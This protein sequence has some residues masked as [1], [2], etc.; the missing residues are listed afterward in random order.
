MPT[1]KE[2][3]KYLDGLTFKQQYEYKLCISLVM[4]KFKI[5]KTQ[6]GKFMTAWVHS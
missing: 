5:S 2:V 1:Q 4:E 6:A 3:F